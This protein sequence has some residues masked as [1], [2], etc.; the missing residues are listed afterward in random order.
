MSI[1]T[2]SV[3]YGI[4]PSAN[5]KT[6]IGKSLIGNRRVPYGVNGLR[7]VISRSRVSRTAVSKAFASGA[8][9]EILPCAMMLFSIRFLVNHGMSTWKRRNSR[10]ILSKVQSPLTKLST[11]KFVRKKASGCYK[12][13]LNLY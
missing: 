5:P 2:L 10:N 9:K 13:Q 12:K 7:T 6:S 1:C 3:C 11:E 4:C 8:A